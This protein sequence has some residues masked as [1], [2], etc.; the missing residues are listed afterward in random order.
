RLDIIPGDKSTE[1]AKRIL[2][3]MDF[4]ERVLAEMFAEIG[5]R[6]DVVLIDCAPSVDVLH[7]AALVAADCLLIPTRLD[8]LAIDGVTEVINSLA[9]IRR[10]SQGAKLLGVVPTFL[11]RQTNESEIQLRALVQKFGKLVLPPVPVDTRLREGPAHGKTIWEYAPDT[12]SVVG[13]P[14]NGKL[15]GGYLQV[16]EKVKEMLR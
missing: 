12:R 4:R 2:A 14:V 7:V 1:P 6:Y 15:V 16:V 3:G 8:H 11:D 5:G 10:R 9:V 13:V